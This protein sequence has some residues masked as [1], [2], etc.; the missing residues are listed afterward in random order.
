MAELALVLALVVLLGG[1]AGALSLLLLVFGFFRAVRSSSPKARDTDRVVRER[2]LLA[3]AVSKTAFSGTGSGCENEPGMADA[4]GAL[5]EVRRVR[6]GE[7]VFASAGLEDETIRLDRR[8]GSLD[9]GT[10]SSSSSASVCVS[11]TGSS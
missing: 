10:D 11:C 7:G 4:D 5:T 9:T 6:R 1:V 3:G 2:V 8:G